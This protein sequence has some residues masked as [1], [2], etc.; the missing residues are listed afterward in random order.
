M[1][2]YEES[3]KIMISSLLDNPTNI[4]SH[5]CVLLCPS[6]EKTDL[7]I[8][9]IR[10]TTAKLHANPN[11]EVTLSHLHGDCPFSKTF[12]ENCHR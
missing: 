4:G 5:F 2:H 10:E 11:Y 6:L 1:R 8:E 3:E 7:A 9:G 12:Q